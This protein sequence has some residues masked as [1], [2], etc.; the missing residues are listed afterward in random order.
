MRVLMISTDRN[1]GIPGSAVSKRMIEYGSIV[2]ELH[3][4]IFSKRT[5][6]I[7]EK[8]IASNVYIYPTHS[9]NIFG[10]I[11]DAVKIGKRILA[12]AFFG[13]TIITTQD[14]FETGIV[15]VILKRFSKFPLQLQLH[16]DAWSTH[17]QFGGLFNFIRVT[18][19]AL[20]T[21]LFA[22]S[23][24]VVSEK[25]RKDVIV[26]G[27][28]VPKK[29]T[30]LPVFV[31]APLFAHAP[32]ISDIHEKYSSK[33]ILILMASRL[34]HEKNILLGL[35]AFS[36]L[37]KKYPNVGLVIVGQGDQLSRIKRYV[38][39]H[40]LTNHVFLEDWQ[41]EIA[42][43]MKT[44]D[45]FLNTSNYEGYGMS[46]IEAG[47]AG[48]PVVTTRVGVAYDLLEDG[49][50]ALICPIGDANC[51]YTKLVSLLENP[52]LRRSLGQEL[53][54][55]VLSKAVSKEVYLQQMKSS[56]ESLF[57]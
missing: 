14:P 21:L 19:I 18:I 13:Q 8:Q 27:H 36:R 41:H 46:V 4:I 7:P 32:V 51:L 28:V 10:Y 34:T 37:V 22:D 55:T 26:R 3:I 44:A 11:F 54:N 48:K 24:R 35:K 39:F 52:S 38:S 43:Y 53:Q 6:V 1:I 20:I 23:V 9:S 29:V 30:I 40:R 2:K 17:F 15:G 16:T 5:Y 25:V 57:S 50:N 31:D 56:F 45:I 33:E 47:A 12:A 49:R 42:S